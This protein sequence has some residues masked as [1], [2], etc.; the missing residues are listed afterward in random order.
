M[1][2]N[3]TTDTISHTNKALLMWLHDDDIYTGNE[4]SR[5][6][7]SDAAHRGSKR[8]CRVLDKGGTE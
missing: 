2:K 8:S 3:K 7:K 5:S 1:N 6:C 4:K